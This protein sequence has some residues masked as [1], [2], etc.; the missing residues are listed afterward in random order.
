[1]TKYFFT[2]ENN[3]KCKPREKRDRKVWVHLYI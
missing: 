3:E 2:K 1:M